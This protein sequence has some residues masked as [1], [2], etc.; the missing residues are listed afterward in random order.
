M[1]CKIQP[2]VKFKLIH[3]DILNIMKNHGLMEDP[4]Q[5]DQTASQAVLV[6]RWYLSH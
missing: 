5:R 1:F 2:I 3:Q 6:R 4:L